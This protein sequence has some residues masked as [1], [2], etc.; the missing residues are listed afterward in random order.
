M[1]NMVVGDVSGSVGGKG[2]G[3]ATL[4]DRTSVLHCS[5]SDPRFQMIS[6]DR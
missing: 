1:V 3:K 2:R 5:R 4:T 6:A